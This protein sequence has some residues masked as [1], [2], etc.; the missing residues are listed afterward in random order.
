[1]VVLQLDI[2]TVQAY[3]ERSVLLVRP[4]ELLQLV[5]LFTYAIV[6]PSIIVPVIVVNITLLRYVENSGGDL[7]QHAHPVPDIVS[8]KVVYVVR[9]NLAH[10][11]RRKIPHSAIYAGYQR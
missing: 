11:L 1:M 4:H 6:A 10:I 9:I 5:L 7:K 3:A 8:V 2:I